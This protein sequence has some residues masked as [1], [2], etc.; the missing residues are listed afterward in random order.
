MS[1]E[2]IGIRKFCFYKEF[3]IPFEEV[4]DQLDKEFSYCWKYISAADDRSRRFYETLNHFYKCVFEMIEGWKKQSEDLEFF[5]RL[6]EEV[7]G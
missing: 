4:M 3:E 6:K 7:Q 2:Y 1:F 5:K